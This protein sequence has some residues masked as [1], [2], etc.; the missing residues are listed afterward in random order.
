MINSM[1]KLTV[2]TVIGI[3]VASTPAVACMSSG[4]DG[5]ASALIWR[6]KPSEIPDD[7]YAIK[8]RF[9]R[10]T[11][12]WSGFVGKVIDG[13][14]KMKNRNYRFYS[15]AGHSCVGLGR[16]EGWIV[17]RV[18]SK[19]PGYLAAVDYGP[20]VFDWIIRLF[21]GKNWHYAGEPSD[22]MEFSF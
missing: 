14:V 16:Q 8:I 9:V 12:T 15:E 21:S 5:Y 22:P 11:E 18:Q 1:F 7:A 13:P 19:R 6:T 10:S 2:A 20:S 4:P 17:V 3:Y